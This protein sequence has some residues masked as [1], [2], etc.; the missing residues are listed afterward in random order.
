M[1]SISKVPPLFNEDRDDYE[2]WKKDVALW[3][4]FTDIPAAKHGIAVHLSLKGR[5]RAASSEISVV[6]MKSDN[7]LK[8]IFVKLDRVF[9][10]DPNWKCFNTYLAFENYRRPNDCSIDEYLSEFDKRHYR[11][12]ECKVSLP[13]AVVACRLLKSCNLS[14]M[15][16]QL[17][18]STTAKMTF[19]DMRATLKKL[20]A[21]SGHL[22][23]GDSDCTVKVEQLVSA[24]ALYATCWR[25]EW[26][27][28]SGRDRGPS[29][30]KFA[31]KD[32]R[33]NPLGAD[34]SVSL[35]AV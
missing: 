20:F 31:N 12:K 13:D 1:S 34:G 26:R 32:H 15:H 3:T 28:S 19:E 8:L 27:G 35:C 30:N 7:G 24:E 25:G 17:A 2:V 9:L 23:T 10:Q 18:L 22:L 5:A 14:D 6:D 21:E 33:T 4:S 29:A 16:F 11:L